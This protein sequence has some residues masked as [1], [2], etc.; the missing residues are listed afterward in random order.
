MVGDILKIS[1]QTD[2]SGEEGGGSHILVM[3]IKTKMTMVIIM[4]M[5]S[6]IM[7]I[8]TLAQSFNEVYSIVLS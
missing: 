4:T 1:T 7:M 8:V 5:M 6:T 2:C 3:M